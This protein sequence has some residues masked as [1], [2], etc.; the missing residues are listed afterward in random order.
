VN[1]AEATINFL[2]KEDDG[3]F[4][5][6]V[7][8]VDSDITHTVYHVEDDK[9]RDLL[10]YIIAQNN[11]D[12]AIVFA[13]T[14]DVADSLAK[15]LCQSGIPAESL[16]GG[17]SENERLKSLSNFENNEISILVATDSAAKNIDVKN[18]PFVINYELPDSAETYSHRLKRTSG[19]GTALSL[20]GHEEKGHLKN[21]NRTL[22]TNLQVIEHA[23]A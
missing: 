6:C 7:L 21:I 15:D 4:A 10:K 18:F 22:P 23:F 2:F 16:H 3:C 12:K 14:K 13:R 17:K 8:E 11:I 1:K 9:K 20:C 5:T 19:T